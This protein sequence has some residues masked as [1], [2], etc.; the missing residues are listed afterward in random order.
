MS[1]HQNP[2]A[3]LQ[4]LIRFN[5]VNPPGD[6]AGCI[7]FIKN[8]LEEAGFE[9]TILAKNPKRPNL[10]TRLPG[11]GE[12]PPFLLYGHIDVVT[13][14]NQEWQY[15]PFEGLIREGFVWGRGA[16]DMKGPLA[17]ML[18]ALIR[19]QT[20]GYKPKGDLILAV[21]CDEEDE[22]LYGADFLTEEHGDLFE[23][24][25]Y[26]IGEI[27]GFSMHVS[28]QRFYP[29][30][31]AEKQKCTL[32]ATIKGP[33]GHGS[34]PLRNGAMAKL[35]ILLNN[36]NSQKL[37]IHITP[38]VK[39]MIEG[40][41]SGMSF[42]ANI[43]VKQLLNPFLADL[44]IDLLGDNG[45][46]FESVLHHTV[47]ATIVSG[48]DKINVVPD[49][50]TLELDGRLL[51]GADPSE[52]I[53]EINRIKG[54]DI[55]FEVTTYIP[56]PGEVDLALF[57]LLASILKEFDQ[58]AIP[59]PFLIGGATDARYFSKLGIQTYGFTPMILPQG[60]D[61]SKLVHAANERIPVEALEF[62]VNTI[63]QLFNKYGL[64]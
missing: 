52:L 54:T 55:D 10:V 14:G 18:T 56:G 51:P 8:L 25:R 41:A 2:V 31:V 29:I 6:E 11:T 7:D 36:L 53:R 35:G 50:I 45:K 59:V 60:M 21:V 43:I 64:N 49:Q 5:T 16:L 1:F 13:V 46:F 15:P 33:S 20:N 28:G 42:P 39:R 34:L 58:K 12:A 63:C 38:V 47:N 24:V 40:F 37:P 27:G 3:L 61:F 4:K 26:A 48:G 23:G 9:T 17:M 44:V 57:P 62:G 30:M 32:K 19:C 22:G